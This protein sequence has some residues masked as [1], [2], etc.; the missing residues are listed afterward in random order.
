MATVRYERSTNTIIVEENGQKIEVSPQ[1]I[2]N[3]LPHLSDEDR[4]KDLEMI[5]HDI[6]REQL[7]SMFEYVKKMKELQQ[8]IEDSRVELGKCMKKIC[9]DKWKVIIK[10]Y[11]DEKNTLAEIRRTIGILQRKKKEIEWRKARVSSGLPEE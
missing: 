9:V 11:V 4:I 5:I 2:R 3:V 8:G 7:S 10:S 6:E 1:E